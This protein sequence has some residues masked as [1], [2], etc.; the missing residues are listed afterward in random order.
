ME[1]REYVNEIA[2]FYYALDNFE[3]TIPTPKNN[4]TMDTHIT[5]PELADGVWYFHMLS[6]DKEA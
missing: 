5:Y 6:I 1:S 2:G 3:N 4:K